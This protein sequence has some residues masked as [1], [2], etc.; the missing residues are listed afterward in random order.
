MCINKQT[1]KVM[2]HFNAVVAL[3]FFWGI[4]YHFR[5]SFV[6]SLYIGKEY[7]VTLMLLCAFMVM[8]LKV[9]KD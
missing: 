5:F 2:A 1:I 6:D 3:G 9:L 8:V 7:L 4:K